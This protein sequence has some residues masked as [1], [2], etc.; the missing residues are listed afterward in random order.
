VGLSLAGAACA[1][2]RRQRPR[3]LLKRSVRA[4]RHLGDCQRELVLPPFVL[5]VTTPSLA[6]RGVIPLLWSPEWRREDEVHESR[7]DTD[8]LGVAAGR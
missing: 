3:R 1:W 5:S 4:Q 8:F 2:G 6:L 7:A